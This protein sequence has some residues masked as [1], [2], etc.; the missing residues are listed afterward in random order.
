MREKRP[1]H[2]DKHFNGENETTSS[3]DIVAVTQIP[4][5]QFVTTDLLM[6]PSRLSLPLWGLTIRIQF[7]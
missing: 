7:W 5:W 1:K 2:Y 4:V 3:G 6:A